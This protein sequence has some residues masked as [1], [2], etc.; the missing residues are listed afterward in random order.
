[1]RRNGEIIIIEDDEEE[2]NIIEMAFTKL[3]YPNKITFIADSTQVIDY[4]SNDSV[5]PFL[6]I[7]DINMPKLD[8]YTLRGLIS[9]DPQLAGKCVPYIFLSTSDLNEHVIKAYKMSVQGYFRKPSG[10]N[11]YSKM[12]EKI[13]TYWKESIVPKPEVA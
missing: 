12:L 6:I 7:S 2:I 5:N 8:G 10:F 4:L 9:N 3:G 1:M 13:V 11:D